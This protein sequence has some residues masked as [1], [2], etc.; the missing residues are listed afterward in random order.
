MRGRL[1]SCSRLAATLDAPRTMRADRSE[2]FATRPA[3]YLETN[4]PKFS[5]RATCLR[6]FVEQYLAG[7]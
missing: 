3:V 2:S 5:Q 6:A 7:G 4:M 1:M